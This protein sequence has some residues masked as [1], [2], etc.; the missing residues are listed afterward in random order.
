[1][2]YQTL[3]IR[4]TM[5]QL[6]RM[7]FMKMIYGQIQKEITRLTTAPLPQLMDIPLK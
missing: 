6:G 2:S 4:M 1:M 3:L 5:E 7:K